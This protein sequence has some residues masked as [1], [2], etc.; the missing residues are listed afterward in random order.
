MHISPEGQSANSL[1]KILEGAVA[2]GRNNDDD[3]KKSA[4]KDE[5]VSP[6]I[7]EPVVAPGVPVDKPEP[8]LRFLLC[9]TLSCLMEKDLRSCFECDDFPCVKL[10]DEW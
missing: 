3:V 9:H 8:Q 6:S 10:Q 5:T 4:M 2:M 1:L 7:D